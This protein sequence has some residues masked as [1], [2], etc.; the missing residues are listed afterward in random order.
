MLSLSLRLLSAHQKFEAALRDHQGDFR[1]IRRSIQEQRQS[2][3]LMD[4]VRRDINDFH[5]GAGV[6]ALSRERAAIENSAREV[7]IIMR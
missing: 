5:E 2:A 1:K 6:D 3:E 4:S 7:E